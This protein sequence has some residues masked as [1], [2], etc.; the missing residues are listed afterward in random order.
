MKEEQLEKYRHDLAFLRAM[1]EQ[2]VKDFE[3]FGYT[4]NFNADMPVSFEHYRLQLAE[5]LR[6]WCKNESDRIPALLYHID[7]P[8][9]LLPAGYGCKAVDKL[10]ELI[11][12]RELIK[13]VL[14]KHYSS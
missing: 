1:S 10:A 4:V 3:R 14:R 7:L 11:L 6:Y 12:Q 5:Q 2:A 8:E 9:H 13:V